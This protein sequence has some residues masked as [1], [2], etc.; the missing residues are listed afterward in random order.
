MELCCKFGVGMQSNDVTITFAT[1][2]NFMV[3]E[4]AES[5]N[6]YIQEDLSCKHSYI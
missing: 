6:T 3:A 1:G 4:M 2:T 5:Q